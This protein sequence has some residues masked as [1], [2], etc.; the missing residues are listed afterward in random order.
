[1]KLLIFRSGA[2]G[3]CIIITP[4]LRYL[5]S[6][7]HELYVQTG[8]RGMEVLQ[9][10]PYVRRLIQHK[11]ETPIEKLAENIEY[12]RR[13]MGCEKVIDF[14]ESLEVSLSQHPRS[15][16]YKLPKQE[17]F[18][19]FNRNFYEYSFEHMY[20]IFPESRQITVV[21]DSHVIKPFYQPELFYKDHEIRDAESHLKK[22]SFNILIGM[23]GSGTHKAWPWIEDFCTGICGKYPELY[24]ITVGDEKCKLIEPQHERILN[25]SGKI[26]MRQAMSITG[27][28]DLVISPDTGIIHASGCY[29]TPKICLLGHNTKE[30]VTKHFINDYSIEADP[31]LAPCAPCLYLIYNMKHQCPLHPATQS[32]V[33]MADG[34]SLKRVFNHFDSVY[35]EL[36]KRSQP[37]SA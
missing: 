7:G 24:L 27:L 23:S 11:E 16:N 19:R 35:A 1:M 18:E 30:C 22:D 32:S 36:K 21:P 9:N 4:V 15:P 20:R 3:D 37:A 13:K 10:N 12:V 6:K 26:S 29:S 2:Y 33:C 34:L 28:V 14:S 31:N 8:K 17:R 25:L 5:H